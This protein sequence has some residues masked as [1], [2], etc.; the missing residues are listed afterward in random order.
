MADLEHQGSFLRAAGDAL[1]LMRVMA[2]HASYP[3][4][5]GGAYQNIWM[6][7]A[8]NGVTVSDVS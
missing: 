3:K 8:A 7:L 2:F 6:Y 4:F 5:G 1:L